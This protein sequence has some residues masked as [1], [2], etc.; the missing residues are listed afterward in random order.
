MFSRQGKIVGS[1][2]TIGQDDD[3]HAEE[4]GHADGSALG[5]FSSRSFNIA[6]VFEQMVANV[7]GRPGTVGGP[8][9]PS[10]S[11]PNP[12]KFI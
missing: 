1:F 8:R 3:L 5:R 12:R 4:W 7:H 10:G 11:R 2:W 6:I 9:K